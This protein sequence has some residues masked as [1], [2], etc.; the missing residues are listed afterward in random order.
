[1]LS[2]DF[3]PRQPPLASCLDNII[4]RTLDL[5]APEEEPSGHPM[6]DRKAAN[7]TSNSASVL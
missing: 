5:D 2:A 1:M 3:R 6:A 4:H 7:T